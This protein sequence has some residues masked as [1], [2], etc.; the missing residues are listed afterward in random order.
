[1][2]YSEKGG[3][4]IMEN[5]NE[6]YSYDQLLKFTAGNGVFFALIY[7]EC[8]YTLFD[9]TFMRE[10][11]KNHFI[12]THVEGQK[13]FTSCETVSTIK[14]SDK[15]DLLPFVSYT[16][17]L[18]SHSNRM[19]IIPYE[20]IEIIRKTIASHK[21]LLQKVS[22]DI[23]GDKS[24][25][26]YFFEERHVDVLFAFMAFS[27]KPNILA[28]AL[29]MILKGAINAEYLCRVKDVIDDYPKVLSKLERG[30]LTAYNDGDSL[31][32][33]FR[34][35][36]IIL[37]EDF[38][39]R[40][41]G[42]FNTR[43]KDI[44]REHK[45]TQY[46]IYI[47]E[48]LYAMGEDKMPNFIRKVS[49]FTTADEIISLA[50]YTADG[51]F[52][53]SE[54]GFKSYAE[55][56]EIKYV[57][58]YDKDGIMV[59]QV[60]DYNSI[61]QIGKFTSWCITKEKRYWDE[62]VQEKDS[63]RRYQFII[64]N[65]NYR[66]SDD[67]SMIGVTVNPSGYV[68]HS[69]SFSNDSLKDSLATRDIG[70]NTMFDIPLHVNITD[71]LSRFG[72]D[73][74]V[75]VT[76]YPYRF[77]WNKETFKQFYE[78]TTDSL[79]DVIMETDKKLALRIPAYHFTELFKS[80]NEVLNSVTIGNCISTLIVLMDF[81]LPAEDCRSVS[82]I[83]IGNRHS[84]DFIE[85]YGNMSSILMNGQAFKRLEEFG[86]SPEQI[87]SRPGTKK[88]AF[89]SDIISSNI[90]GVKNFI[91]ENGFGYAIRN[92][93]INSEFCMLLNRS[94]T[95]YYSVDLLNLVYEF[96]HKLSDITTMVNMR[97][98]YK[99]TISCVLDYG[100]TFEKEEEIDSVDITSSMQEILNHPSDTKEELYAVAEIRIIEYYA[101]KEK[102][103]DIIRYLFEEG[104]DCMEKCAFIYL[105]RK[106]ISIMKEEVMSDRKL[107]MEIFE[108]ALDDYNRKP[109]RLMDFIVY[110]NP[111]EIDDKVV[112]RMSMF[113][114][115]TDRYLRHAIKLVSKN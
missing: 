35:I 90:E 67:L 104:D 114:E 25:E 103:T 98:F 41:T 93:L 115:S 89:L 5:L 13:I 72:I 30:T 99:D 29:R 108:I 61:K 14:N 88:A 39:T 53:W 38:V 40:I 18:Y 22:N 95:V 21:K 94:V 74:S 4:R 34:E 37:K 33:V 46:E 10:K 80:N 84:V 113:L 75:F 68:T 63:K 111:L 106:F 23:F 20:F 12:L 31:Y 24:I 43:Q 58:T 82:Y 42:M 48:K 81:S 49:T 36:D 76:S 105:L 19:Y 73:N 9:D 11:Y 97:D 1:M 107:R 44:L 52:E 54:E 3:L 16:S 47:L 27:D 45:F 102:D 2:L 26:D 60:F 112:Q 51:K 28:W 86:I 55:D 17:R 71:I 87:L 56:H 92:S 78:F 62:Y 50:E 66:E 100:C 15:R 32:A 64:L 65:F 79:M 57:T 59:I 96:G 101:E 69:H 85:T 77:V 110:E 109:N 83:K 91:K 7:A 6:I 8:P 70:L